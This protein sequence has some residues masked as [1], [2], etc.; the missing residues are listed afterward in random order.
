M[1]V[2]CD[3]WYCMRSQYT[4][5]IQSNMCIINMY[6]NW[7]KCPQSQLSVVI[8]LEK[9]CCIWFMYPTA[10]PSIKQNKPLKIATDSVTLHIRPIVYLI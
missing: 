9:H 5:R 1:T 10:A 4:R 6:V 8:N 3:I 2:I 7:N